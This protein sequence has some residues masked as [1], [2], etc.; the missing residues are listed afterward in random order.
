MMSLKSILLLAINI[1]EQDY[2]KRLHCNVSAKLDERNGV[3]LYMVALELKV[4][5][6]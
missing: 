6:R 4:T 5:G 1:V 2:G 3:L